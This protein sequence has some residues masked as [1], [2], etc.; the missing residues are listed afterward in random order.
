V[1]GEG[2]KTFI[3]RG[4]APEEEEKKLEKG[5]SEKCWSAGVRR[6]LDENPVS[7]EH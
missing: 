2:L 6:T 7:W 5:P 3:M 4:A 1:E